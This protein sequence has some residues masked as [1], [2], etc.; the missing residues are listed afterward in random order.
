MKKILSQSGFTL[1]EIMVA[2]SILSI[3]MMVI[4]EMHSGTMI[5]S[6]RAEEITI[7]TMLARSQLHEVQLDFEKGMTKGEFPKE[8]KTLEGTF[9]EPY[10]RYKWEAKVSK[11][12]IPIPPQ[13]E[14]DVKF[15]SSIQSY[16]QPLEYIASLPN[17]SQETREVI[18]LLLRDTA[19]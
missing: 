18:A 14:G 3:S 15:N 17:T 13:P 11:V 5:T 9:D 16:A 10:E 12:E 7:A 6:R 8:N 4:M 1:L 2:V 19:E